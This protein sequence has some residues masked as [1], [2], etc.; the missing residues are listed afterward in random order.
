M[1]DVPCYI[2]LIMLYMWHWRT[3]SH[4]NIVTICWMCNIM[5]YSMWYDM[6]LQ[7]DDACD[8]IM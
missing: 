4:V 5:L 3:S 6:V 2:T 8:I 7:Y 1:T